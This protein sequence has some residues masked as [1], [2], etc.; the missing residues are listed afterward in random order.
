MDI[1]CERRCC[2]YAN[3]KADLPGKGC[4]SSM[5]DAPTTR[6]FGPLPR[7]REEIYKARCELYGGLCGLDTHRDLERGQDDEK[8]YGCGYRQRHFMKRQPLG[9]RIRVVG[10]WM[11]ILV[12]LGY[13]VYLS[14]RVG[15]LGGG[16]VVDKGLEGPYG[17]DDGVVFPQLDP[18]APDFLRWE[19]N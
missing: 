10:P 15:G 19:G 17:R 18:A 5:I 6:A 3:G 13:C 16:Q 9:R 4:G 1:L 14:G 7:H 2:G 12:L 11:I 8:K